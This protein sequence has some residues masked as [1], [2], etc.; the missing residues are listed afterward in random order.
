MWFHF[1]TCKENIIF[2]VKNY[3]CSLGASLVSLCPREFGQ[4][5]QH[6][7]SID[8]LF[9]VFNEL[10]SCFIIIYNYVLHFLNFNVFYLY[11]HSIYLPR[12]LVFKHSLEPALH[13]PSGMGIQNYSLCIFMYELYNININERTNVY[14]TVYINVY[15]YPKA[16]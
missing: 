12:I 13:W 9:E 15:K 2:H 16:L 4:N 8:V 1:P 10:S 3:T 5:Q 6:S 14:I 11:M 7:P